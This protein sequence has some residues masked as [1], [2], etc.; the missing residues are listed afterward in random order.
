MAT[1]F[2]YIYVIATSFFYIYL[3]ATSFFYIYVLATKYKIYWCFC[4]YHPSPSFPLLLLLHRVS[5][6]KKLWFPLP[7]ASDR[8]CGLF[9]MNIHGERTVTQREIWTSMAEPSSRPSHHHWEWRFG[10][11]QKHNNLP[12]V[13]TKHR[14]SFIR[15]VIDSD[16]H[17][18]WNRLSEIWLKSTTHREHYNTAGFP[19]W[20][21]T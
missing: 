21:C 15:K 4:C 9:E 16:W 14:N 1:S 13:Q 19:W 11:K 20:W 18:Q 12:W 7:S 8:R 10:R 2:F 5:I 3:L 6:C 17:Q